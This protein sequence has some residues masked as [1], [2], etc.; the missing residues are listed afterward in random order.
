MCE[1]LFLEACAIS[2]DQGN[3]LWQA[4]HSF[5]ENGT[6]KCYLSC[7]SISGHLCCSCKRVPLTSDHAARVCAAVFVCVCVCVCV[8]VTVCVCVCTGCGCAVFVSI[9]ES[10]YPLNQCYQSSVRDSTL[11]LLPLPFP[12]PLCVNERQHCSDLWPWRR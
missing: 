1:W 7:R 8:C 6:P 5:G 4:S 9:R 11:R 10:V 2:C 12:L 3:A